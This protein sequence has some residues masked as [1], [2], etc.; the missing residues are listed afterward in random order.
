MSLEEF[1]EWDAYFQYKYEIE[2]KAYE[3]S[4]ASRRR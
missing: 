1:H 3:K 4:K 2:K